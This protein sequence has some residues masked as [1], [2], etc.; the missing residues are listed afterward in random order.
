MSEIKLFPHNEEAVEDMIDGLSES[1]FAFM[2]RATGTGK[3][4][5]LIKLMDELMRNKRVLFVTLHDAMF[6]QFLK[7]DMPS[8][9]T[10]KED[11]EALD[12][13]LYH[14]IPKHDANWYYNNYDFFI[15]DE[16][17]HCG[18]PKWGEVIGELSEL[19]KG[20]DQNLSLKILMASGSA[21]AHEK[22]IEAFASSQEG[23]FNEKP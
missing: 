9:G 19:V 3:S 10:S 12:C 15:F 13:I 7:R 14:S 1:N 23:N 17:Q 21:S 8:C 2:E 4:M 11:Y 22:I 18:A 16:A 6:N 5:I 20:V